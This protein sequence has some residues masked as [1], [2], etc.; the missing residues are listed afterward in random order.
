MTPEEQKSFLSSVGTY[1]R[2]EVAKAIAPLETRIRELEAKGIEYK[3]VYQ[4]ANDYR[5][6]DC[7]T[8]DGG[9]Y[10]ALADAKAMD[11]PGQSER[12]QLAA[13]GDTHR[14]PTKGR[15]S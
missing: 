7:V 14:V 9:M 15:T 2:T 8:W 5:R 6:G 12:W 13:K 3:G 4:R 1:I 10:V 11:G